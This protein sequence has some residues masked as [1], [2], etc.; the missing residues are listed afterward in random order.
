MIR[1][2]LAQMNLTVGDIDGNSQLIADAMD[3]AARSGA[4]VLAVPELAVTGY[5]PEDLVMKKAFVDANRRAVDALAAGSSEVLTVIGFV[6]ADDA[7]VYNAAAIC[8]SGRLLAIYRK[9][10]LPN[11]G[12]FDEHRYFTPGSDHHLFESEVGV[13]GVC[14]CEDAWSPSGPVVSQGD[15]GAQ[16]VVN[17][18]ASPFHKNKLNERAEM[19]GER[20]RLAHASIAYVNTVGGQDELVFDGGSLVVGPDGEVVCRLPQFEEDFA[21]IDVPLGD[22]GSSRP[23]NV[24]RTPIELRAASGEATNQITQPLEPA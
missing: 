10:L 21:V 1:V 23:A 3:R 14:I 6:D 15:A 18:N 5:P 17:I 4:Q 7:H 12:V 9:Q 13:L 11:Y 22:A 19:L 24:T 2:A 8:Q 16:L 20:A